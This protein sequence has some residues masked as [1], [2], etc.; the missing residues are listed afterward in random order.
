VFIS[1]SQRCLALSALSTRFIQPVTV[2]QWGGGLRSRT[3][4]RCL[5][6]ESHDKNTLPTALPRRV[7]DIGAHGAAALQ[8]ADKGRLRGLRSSYATGPCI[9][10]VTVRIRSAGCMCSCDIVS[11]SNSGEGGLVSCPHAVLSPPPQVPILSSDQA[12]YSHWQVSL[13]LCFKCL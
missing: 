7:D 10:S 11:K 12:G 13:H 3:L 9:R 1:A 6:R 2:N 8:T 5:V 4:N